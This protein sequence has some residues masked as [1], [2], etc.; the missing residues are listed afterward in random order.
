[1]CIRDSLPCVE[2]IGDLVPVTHQVRRHHDQCRP[3][4]F[5]GQQGECLNCLAQT[6][7]VSEQ[8]API[9]EYPGKPSCWNGHSAPFQRAN[10]S[11][12]CLSPCVSPIPNEA[13]FFHG[14]R[15]GASQFIGS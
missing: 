12:A 14:E 1:M 10:P 6:H 13:R 2:E 3:C 15:V 7:F 5:S 9:G 4:L 11:K 8:C